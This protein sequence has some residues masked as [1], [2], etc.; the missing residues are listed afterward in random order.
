MTKI[1]SSL[2]KI[3]KKIA[4]IF[5]NA[6]DKAVALWYNTYVMHQWA[7]S[8]SASVPR[9]QQSIPRFHSSLYFRGVA[10]VVSRQF[11]VLVVSCSTEHQHECRNP[12]KTLNF[13]HF[14]PNTKSPKKWLWPHNWPQ[15]NSIVFYQSRRSEGGIA[16]VSGTGDRGF[17][18]RRFDQKIRISPTEVLIFLLQVG[19]PTWTQLR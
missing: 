6:I 19:V 14:Q 16:P 18:S 15:Q 4:L 1:R 8:M 17:E 10:K 3:S 12:L 9:I 7:I 2:Q 11:R 5:R 13:S